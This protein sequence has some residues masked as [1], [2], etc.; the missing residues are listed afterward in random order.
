MASNAIFWTACSFLA[1]SLNANNRGLPKITTLSV[2]YH[3]NNSNKKVMI[4]L[5]LKGLLGTGPSFIRLG[6]QGQHSSYPHRYDGRIIIS[7]SKT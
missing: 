2:T 5:G 7:V 6:A 4:L 1:S 3:D